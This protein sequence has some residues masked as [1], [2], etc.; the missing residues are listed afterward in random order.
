MPKVVLTEEQIGTLSPD[1]VRY[2]RL[3]VQGREFN[4]REVNTRSV[5]HN[6]FVVIP[7]AIDGDGWEFVLPAAYSNPV[8][9]D[10]ANEADASADTVVV[11]PVPAPPSNAKTK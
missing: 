1:L 11:T 2:P 5:G 6:L 10:T 9:T 3:D 7:A 4:R 8:A